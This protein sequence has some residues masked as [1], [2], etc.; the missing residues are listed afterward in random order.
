MRDGGCGMR[1]AGSAVRVMVTNEFSTT[2]SRIPHPASR[3]L[4]SP[5]SKNLHRQLERPLLL[6]IQD[7]HAHHL[8]RHFLATLAEYRQHDRVL[9][10]L[11]GRR[12]PDRS[13][14]A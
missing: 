14:N 10:R 6:R 1:D 2:A 8:A 5:G 4:L 11:A 12:L 13:L 3:L 7:A 9:P